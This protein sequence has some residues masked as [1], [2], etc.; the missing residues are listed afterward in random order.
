MSILF[1]PC[2]DFYV[3]YIFS[4]CYS[5]NQKGGMSKL[6]ERI[7]ELRKSLGLTL[8]KFG[9]RL[10]VG[11]TAIN[12]LEKG[13]NNVTDQMVK[14]ICREFS[15]NEEWLRDG[16]GEP[17]IIPDDDI[18]AVVENILDN[19]DDDFYRIAVDVLRTYDE[20][21]DD[22]KAIL[23]NFAKIL[24]QNITDRKD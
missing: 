1:V 11:K 7:K 9:E 4:T 12:K 10:G 5:I 14:S 20:L 22:G 17:Y 21:N 19:P 8:E 3:D 16:V 6:N 13:E 18:T 15:V 2:R 24:V 23:R